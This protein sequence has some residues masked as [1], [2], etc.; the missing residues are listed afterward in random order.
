MLIKILG[1]EDITLTVINQWDS[2]SAPI[3]LCNLAQTCQ[4]RV[5]V[6]LLFTEFLSPL[7]EFVVEA[8][9]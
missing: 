1:E 9:L 2:V 3:N 8:G 4:R 7:F 5:F 6:R